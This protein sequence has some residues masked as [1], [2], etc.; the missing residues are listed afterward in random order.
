LDNKEKYDKNKTSITT[1]NNELQK[2]TIINNLK[3]YVKEQTIIHNKATKW[4]RV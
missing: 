2:S 4:G 1:E 3:N